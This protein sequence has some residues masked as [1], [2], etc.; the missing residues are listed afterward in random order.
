MKNPQLLCSEKGT[1]GPQRFR[2]TPR[3]ASIT[4]VIALHDVS[5]F[6]HCIEK[7]EGLPEPVARLGCERRKGRV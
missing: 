2:L 1:Q 5:H 4:A 6:A 3:D 7:G